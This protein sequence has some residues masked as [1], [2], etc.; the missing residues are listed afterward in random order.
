[1]IH[2]IWI[3][4]ALPLFTFPVFCEVG[5]CTQGK[6]RAL[7]FKEEKKWNIVTVAFEMWCVWDLIHLKSGFAFSGSDFKTKISSSQEGKRSDHSGTISTQL[8]S[9]FYKKQIDYLPI[10]L[11]WPLKLIS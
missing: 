6:N 8:F 5:G 10:S 4:K 2:P 3:Q 11:L 7:Q 1:M 9:S